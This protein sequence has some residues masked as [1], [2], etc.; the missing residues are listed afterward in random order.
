MNVTAPI[1]VRVS[2]LSPEK[3]A[4]CRGPVLIPQDVLRLLVFQNIPLIKQIGWFSKV[5]A[6]F[7]PDSSQLDDI[8]IWIVIIELHSSNVLRFGHDT[9]IHRSAPQA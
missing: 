1:V 4:D 2:E 5:R 8:W 3:D 6:N 7:A 9:P